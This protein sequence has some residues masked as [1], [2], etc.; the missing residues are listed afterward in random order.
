MDGFKVNGSIS[1]CVDLESQDCGHGVHVR[2]FRRLFLSAADA[3]NLL[4]G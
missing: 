1:K 2:G 3:M 4:V